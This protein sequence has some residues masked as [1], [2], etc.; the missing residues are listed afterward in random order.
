[1]CFHGSF[2]SQ[3]GCS[4]A[5]DTPGQSLLSPSSTSPTGYIPLNPLISSRVFGSTAIDSVGGT[6][7]QTDEQSELCYLAL[8]PVY[9][10]SFF[11]CPKAGHVDVDDNHPQVA[12]DI[13]RGEKE[14]KDGHGHQTS[15]DNKT[16]H[17]PD[18]HGQKKRRSLVQTLAKDESVSIV[19]S[20]IR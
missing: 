8:N 14:G 3:M 5:R 7:R 12:V 6:T 19:P 11:L 10:S 9:E 4:T 13:F 17:R 18:Q 1:M 2:A 20:P 15:A 16:S